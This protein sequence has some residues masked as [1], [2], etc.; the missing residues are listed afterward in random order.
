M[1]LLEFFIYSIPYTALA[2]AVGAVAQATINITN[3]ANFT[4]HYITAAVEQAA[5]LVVNWSGTVQIEDTGVGQNFFDRAI[6]LESIRGTGSL[7][8]MLQ[9]PRQIR[10]GSG[11]VVT[12]T[13]RVATATNVQI[14]LHGHKVREV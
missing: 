6:A 8:Y 14:C 12:L 2:A 4:V 1:Q 5:V 9:T 11:L 7:P 3:D 10:G 13:N